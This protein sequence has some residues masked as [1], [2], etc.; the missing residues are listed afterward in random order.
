MWHRRNLSWISSPFQ[1]ATIAVVFACL[2]TCL[3]YL[4]SLGTWHRNQYFFSHCP[5]LHLYILPWK[6]IFP[7]WGMTAVVPSLIACPVLSNTSAPRPRLII[8]LSLMFTDITILE[9]ENDLFSMMFFTSLRIS[10]VGWRK[11]IRMTWG[12]NWPLIIAFLSMPSEP[13]DRVCLDWKV[14]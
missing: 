10:Y 5:V 1:N 11:R 8:C 9:R 6:F 14:G 4:D 12:T 13:E 3:F 7:F 2:V